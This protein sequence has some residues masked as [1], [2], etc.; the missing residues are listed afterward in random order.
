MGV[1][2]GGEDDSPAQVCPV[3]QG[4]RLGSLGYEARKSSPAVDHESRKTFSLAG[5]AVGAAIEEKSF[6]R[7]GPI[8]RFHEVHRKPGSEGPGQGSPPLGLIEKPGRG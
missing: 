7:H 4:G 1:G 6:V 8:M 5:E 2:K 3:P